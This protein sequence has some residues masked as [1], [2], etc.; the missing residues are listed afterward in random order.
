MNI[1]IFI[2]D[3]KINNYIH[4]NIYNINLIKKLDEGSYGV[5]YK[6]DKN[7]V[8]KIYKRSLY[9]SIIKNSNDIIPKDNE[10]REINFFLDYLKDKSINNNF[11]F[12]DVKVVGYT[13]S[14]YFI[15][16]YNV[17]KETFIMIMPYYL[18]LHKLINK[19]K[20][21]NINNEYYKYGFIIKLMHRLASIQLILLNKY[22]CLNLD[23][24]LKNFMLLNDSE[25]NI[26][27]IINIDF[28]LIFK[29]DNKKYNLEYDYKFWP[30]GKNIYLQNIIPYIICINALSIL[31]GK[32]YIIDLD[33]D[34]INNKINILK[35][36]KNI[37]DI[38]KNAILL[39]LNLKNFIDLLEDFIN[40]N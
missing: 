1:K 22:N 9:N 33:H 3:S 19:Y 37:Y 4:N 14:N 30:K 40:N 35:N 24:K 12:V 8:I 29:D 7:L 23:Y 34:N 16:N 5:I 25:I 20:F 26:D 18:Q 32:K 6:I 28:S 38:F 13:C 2:L 36:K 17:K 27:K 10:N 11:F 21:D 31:Y 39:K 15:N